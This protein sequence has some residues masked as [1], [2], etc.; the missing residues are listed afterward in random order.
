ML[1]Q[2]EGSDG[3]KVCN[4]SMSGSSV[5]RDKMEESNPAAISSFSCSVSFRCLGLPEDGETLDAA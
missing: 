1:D 5:N 3:G 4:S 2:D